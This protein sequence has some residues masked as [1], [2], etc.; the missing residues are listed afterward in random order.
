MPASQQVLGQ[1]A[2]RIAWPLM[3]WLIVVSCPGPGG[4]VW[5]PLQSPRR[6]RLPGDARARPRRYHG[7]RP[8]AGRAVRTS[9]CVVLGASS[10]SHRLVR[11]SISAKNGDNDGRGMSSRADRGGERQRG[12]LARPEQEALRETAHVQRPAENEHR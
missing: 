7:A 5:P 12:A 8:G 3:A 10:V 1:L 2:V 9:C 6:P 4:R 11:E